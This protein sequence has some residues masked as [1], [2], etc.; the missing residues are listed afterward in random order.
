MKIYLSKLNKK[1]D[2]LVESLKDAENEIKKTTD[3][4]NIGEL[5]KQD[6]NGQQIE[7]Q[8]ISAYFNEQIQQKTK[9]QEEKESEQWS[10]GRIILRVSKSKLW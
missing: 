1:I 4:K 9:Q 5:I 2:I 6:A 7:R 3:R 10:R 8:S